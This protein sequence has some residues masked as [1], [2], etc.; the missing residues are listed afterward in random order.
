MEETFTLFKEDQH[1]FI[2]QTGNNHVP[3]DIN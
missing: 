3:V 2:D 1:F